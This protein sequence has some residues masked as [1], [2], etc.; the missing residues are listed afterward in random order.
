METILSYIKDN[1]FWIKDIFTLILVA[2]ATIISILA[3]RRARAT[4]L[5]PIRDE[6]VKR[7]SEILTEILGFFPKEEGSL[8]EGFDYV[9]VASIS[10][11]L[12]LKDYGFVFKDHRETQNR[13]DEIYG[14]W[15]FCG[16]GNVIKDVEIV[17]M[18]ADTNKQEEAIREVNQVGKERFEDAK[19]GIIK[20]DK[21]FFTRTH[22]EFV[23][24]LAEY[25]KNPFLPQRI[26]GI[27]NKLISD[28]QINL[29]VHLKN[30]LEKFTKEFCQ[31]YFSGDSYPNISPIGVYNDFNH[32]R[33]HHN[34][35]LNKLRIEIR[36]YLRID[37]KW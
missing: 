34:S 12:A 1:I 36:D 30:T 21:V 37:D 20:I 23:D 29:S 24:K 6:V 8:D 14:G 3:Y 35:D 15:L 11:F 2:T 33:I 26:Q 31:K 9:G 13:I 32:S 18:F 28:V 25:S 19:K 27:L 4:V 22:K 17:G 5:Q 10:A 16:E 7:Q